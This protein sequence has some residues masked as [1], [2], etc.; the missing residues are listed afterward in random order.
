MAVQQ[1]KQIRSAIKIN[2]VNLQGDQEEIVNG[3]ASSDQRT[4]RVWTPGHRDRIVELGDCAIVNVDNHVRDLGFQ[5]GVRSA[6]E[7][8]TAGPDAARGRGSA[9]CSWRDGGNLKLAVSNSTA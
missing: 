8:P 4:G 7:G 6:A 1:T 5:V 2:A 9:G 3:H